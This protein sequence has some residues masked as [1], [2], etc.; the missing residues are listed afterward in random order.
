M[1]VQADLAPYAGRKI[2]LELINEP[3][4]WSFEAAY[5]AAITVQT[6]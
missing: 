3:T 5:W 1:D 6:R 2:L 4:G